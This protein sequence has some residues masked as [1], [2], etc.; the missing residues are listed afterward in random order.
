M[1]LTQVYNTNASGKKNRADMWMTVDALETAIARPNIETLVI[2]SGDSDFGPLVSKLREYGR[3][4]VGIGPQNGSHHLLIK[5]CDEFIFLDTIL[6][7]RQSTDLTPEH[8]ASRQLLREAVDIFTQRGELPVL[9]TKLKQMMLSMDASFNEMELGHRQFRAFLEDNGD[10]VRLYKKGLQVYAGPEDFAL[11][12][13]WG[14]DAAVPEA[15]IPPEKEITPTEV[16][17]PET[18]AAEIIPQIIPQAESR[19][20]PE[21][22][23][24]TSNPILLEIV[25]EMLAVEVVEEW[26]RGRESAEQLA[27]KGMAARA[28]DFSEAAQY[29]LAASRL[30]WEVAEQ[31]PQDHNASSTL[32]WMMASYASC[33]AAELSQAQKDYDAAGRYYLS[34]FLLIGLLEPEVEH[35]RGLTSSMLK[36]YWWNVGRELEIEFE[37]AADAAGIAIQAAQHENLECRKK[38]QLITAELAKVHPGLL[39]QIARQMRLDQEEAPEGVM[40]A[41]QIDHIIGKALSGQMVE[42][43]NTFEQPPAMPAE[44]HAEVVQEES[45]VREDSGPLRD[46]EKDPYLQILW[47]DIVGAAIPD[48]I[49]AN[50]QMAHYLIQTTATLRNSD[51]SAAA[52]NSLIACKMMVDAV[53]RGESDAALDDLRWFMGEYAAVKGSEL[54][55]TQSYSAARPYYLAFFALV[56]MDSQAWEKMNG[57]INPILMQYW[58]DAGSE[59]GLAPEPVDEPVEAAVNALVHPNLAYRNNW[60]QRTG[61]LI[62]VNAE[63]MRS[64]ATQEKQAGQ[65][66]GRLVAIEIEKIFESQV[67]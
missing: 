2:V 64:F 27:K 58:L 40:V 67:L 57:L 37:P 16:D 53:E 1:E 54:S 24:F 38:W 46:I 33:R 5:A 28:H 19:A 25:N 8:Q 26:G 21:E 34:Y 15:E 42:S 31:S 32:K 13:N 30:M 18:I 14:L 48:A 12:E 7:T 20:G 65:A 50:A 52:R 9:A 60:A 6:G 39:E 22:V 11:P 43:A 44:T 62:E 4:V 35:T 17:N 45:V 59:L 29:Y 3:Y 49:L 66:R 55:L 51:S 36:H 61:E 10:L 47:D 56:K 63:L 41:Q 23:K